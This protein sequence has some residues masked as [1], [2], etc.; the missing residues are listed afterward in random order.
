MMLRSYG[1]QRFVSFI[2]DVTLLWTTTV[3]SDKLDISLRPSKS[4]GQTRLHVLRDVIVQTFRF[5]IRPVSNRKWL[6]WTEEFYNL[7]RILTF[8]MFTWFME[9]KDRSGFGLFRIPKLEFE[10]IGKLPA[11]L[12]SRSSADEIWQFWNFKRM[13]KSRKKF[14]MTQFVLWFCQENSGFVCW[15]R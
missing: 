7:M 4:I 9:S 6:K 15:C 2:N 3:L 1:P 14:V 13:Q 12:M 10:S 11:G 5:I 8:K